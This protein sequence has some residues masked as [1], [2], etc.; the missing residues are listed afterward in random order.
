MIRRCLET[1]Y[2]ETSSLR[3]TALTLMGLLN[4][5]RTM[6]SRVASPNALSA[7]MQFNPVTD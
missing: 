1:L 5:S 2:W 4:N 6:R 3:A 7:A